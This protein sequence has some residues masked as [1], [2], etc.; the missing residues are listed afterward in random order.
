MAAD[1]PDL[2]EPI[3]APGSLSAA[4]ARA[5]GWPAPQV[6][7]GV[8]LAEPPG[9]PIRQVV[10]AG[11]HRTAQPWASVSKLLVALAVLLAVEE[12]TLT[13]DEPAGPPGATVRHLLAHASGLAPDER[14]VLAP[15]GARRI[16]SNA[17]YEVLAET[18][19]A[20]SGMPFDAYL[21]EGVLWPLGMEGTVLPPGASP[22]S[23]VVGPLD[24]MVRLASELLAPRLLDRS[25]L[26]EATQVAFPGLAGVVPGV[27]RFD[28]CDWGLGVEVRDGKVPHWTGTRASARTYGHFGRSG[29][30]L[31]VDPE[32]GCACCGLT[33]RSFGPWALAVWPP[34]ADAV[35][36]AV[37]ATR[38][39]G[40]LGSAR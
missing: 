40:P 27:G 38:A 33:G 31:W 22:A 11:A 13:L 26:A 17:G 18:L 14:R 3:G 24:D 34:F 10:R 37:S 2:D 25:T 20:R 5:R 8:V 30:F 16:Y 28:P 29:S 9:G 32:A 36:E 4:L 15:P 1:P 6:A 21:A 35:L 7:V 23:G 19:A 39:S 12:G